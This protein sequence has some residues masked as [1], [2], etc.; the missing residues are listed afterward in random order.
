MSL[1]QYGNHAPSH[2]AEYALRPVSILAHRGDFIGGRNI[3]SRCLLH[4]LRIE[5]EVLGQPAFL[6]RE[7]VTSA[8]LLLPFHN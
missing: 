6:R 8:H 5:I 1:A 7:S 4:V 2:Q 3:P